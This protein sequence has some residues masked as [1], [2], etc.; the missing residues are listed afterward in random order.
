M[1]DAG[2][3]IYIV[4]ICV[5]VFIYASIW[6][7]K[8]IF[9]NKGIVPQGFSLRCS[10]SIELMERHEFSIIVHI[11]SWQLCTQAQTQAYSYIW[12]YQ[13]L[14]QALHA[15]FPLVFP[16]NVSWIQCGILL[17]TFLI[18]PQIPHC[19]LFRKPLWC[20]TCVLAVEYRML[21]AVVIQVLEKVFLLPSLAISG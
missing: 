21:R 9:I 20:N 11:I 12:V 15:S 16:K 8:C 5:S 19:L 2:T 10:G 6:K 17:L 1:V 3:C 13:Y 7:H 14:H 18:F 4:Y